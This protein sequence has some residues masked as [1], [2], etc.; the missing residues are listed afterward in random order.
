LG[1][2]NVPIRF[3]PKDDHSF[4]PEDVVHLS[5]AYEAV[6]GELGLVNRSDPITI[7]VATVVIDLA[8]KGERNP[9]KLCHDA[10]KILRS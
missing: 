4:G 2:L 1:G 8:K 6:L 10:V 5:A 3:A 9:D 7:E